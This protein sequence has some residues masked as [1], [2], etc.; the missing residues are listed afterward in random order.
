MFRGETDGVSNAANR[1]K[2]GG[3]DNANGGDFTI[4]TLFT[5]QKRPSAQDGDQN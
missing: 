3:V 1:S 4:G 5:S 2:I